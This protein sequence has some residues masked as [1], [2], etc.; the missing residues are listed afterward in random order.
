MRSQLPF[1]TDEEIDYYYRN[2]TITKLHQTLINYYYAK[3]FGG[4]VELNFAPKRQLITLM[5]MMKRRMMKDGFIYLPQL[6][7][8]NIEGKMS[9]RVIQNSKFLNKIETSPLYKVIMEE[10]YSVIVDLKKE[11]NSIIGILSS[12][13]NSKFTFVDFDMQDVI[14]EPIIINQDTLSDEFI[15]FIQLI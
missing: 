6:L 13:I 10:K 14:N 11:N 8:G 5:V 9:N 1:I 4:F 7:S 12:L 2:C 3:Y 15:N